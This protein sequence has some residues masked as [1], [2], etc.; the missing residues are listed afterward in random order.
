MDD[1]S[2]FVAIIPV[3]AITLGFWANSIGRGMRRDC[4]SCG[5]NT[6]PRR[7]EQGR[8]VCRSCGDPAA[9]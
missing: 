3:L 2:I 6:L 4:P 7:N 5:R 9:E 8:K 1:G